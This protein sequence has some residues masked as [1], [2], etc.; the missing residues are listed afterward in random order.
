MSITSRVIAAIIGPVEEPSPADAARKAIELAGYPES[1]RAQTIARFN[2][3]MWAGKGVDESL[4]AVT[5]WADSQVR[6]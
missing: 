6:Q 2:R 1:I 3:R 4:R 5:A